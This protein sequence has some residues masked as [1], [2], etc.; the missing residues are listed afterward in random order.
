M[1]EKAGGYVGYARNTVVCT[2]GELL[3]KNME[4]ELR[5]KLGNLLRV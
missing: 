3:V 4:R 2:V 5:P 1:V